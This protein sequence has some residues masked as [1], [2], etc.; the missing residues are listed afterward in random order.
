MTPAY[1][2]M[3]FIINVT[4]LPVV[5]SLVTL[6]WKR[7]TL[8]LTYV[9][10]GV[11]LFGTALVNFAA[12]RLSANRM[13]NLPLLHFYTLIEFVGWSFFYRIVFYDVRW[14]ERVFWPFLFGGAVLIVGNSLFLESP[15]VFNSNAKSVTQSFYIL[16]SIYYFFYNFGKADFSQPQ[17][18]S[19]GLINTGVLLYY[20]GSLFI[21]MFSKMLVAAQTSR[22]DQVGFWLLNSLLTLVFQILILTSILITTKK[23]S[24]KK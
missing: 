24:R 21:F 6:I 20:S 2:V 19:V 7:R 23:S 22:E 3:R 16:L 12:G 14:I 4:W 17:N 5:L 11:Y 8:S 13:N 1:D 10:I 15:F 9:V 18:L